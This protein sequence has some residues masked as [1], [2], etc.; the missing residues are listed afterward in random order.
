MANE[1]RRLDKQIEVIRR[2]LGKLY[3][4]GKITLEELQKF[5]NYLEEIVECVK[6]IDKV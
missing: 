2:L 3:G 5:H 4:K 6:L 1:E